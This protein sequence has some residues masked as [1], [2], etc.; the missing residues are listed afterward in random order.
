ME[1]EQLEVIAQ[2]WDRSII[3]G[4]SLRKYCGDTLHTNAEQHNKVSAQMEQVGVAIG[5]APRGEPYSKLVDHDMYEQIEACEKKGF[6]LYK[7]F[8]QGVREL[9]PSHL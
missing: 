1:T 9:D 8:P 2:S 4:S 5:L 3:P 7:Q 6:V